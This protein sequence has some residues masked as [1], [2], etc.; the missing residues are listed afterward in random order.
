M[1][2]G[3]DQTRFTGVSDAIDHHEQE[4][5]RRRAMS[6]GNGGMEGRKEERKPFLEK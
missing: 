5:E 1:S 4:R 2:R 6:M 3:D